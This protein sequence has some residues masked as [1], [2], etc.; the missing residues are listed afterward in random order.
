MQGWRT[1]QGRGR[2]VNTVYIKMR[3]VQET[4]CLARSKGSGPGQLWDQ[5]G[6]AAQQEPYRW[7]CRIEIQI[8]GKRMSRAEPQPSPA[9]MVQLEDW[10]DSLQKVMPLEERKQFCGGVFSLF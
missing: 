10:T 2:G 8:G 6:R 3:R 4:R 1:L 9:Q 7:G 5:S